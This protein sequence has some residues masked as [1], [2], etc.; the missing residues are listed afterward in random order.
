LL[1]GEITSNDEENEKEEQAIDVD[2]SQDMSS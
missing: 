2:Q 1:N